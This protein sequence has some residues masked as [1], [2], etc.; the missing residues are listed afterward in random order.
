MK[1]KIKQ[2]QR[3]YG[4]FTVVSMRNPGKTQELS[5]RAQLAVFN[6]LFHA[7]RINLRHDEWS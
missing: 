6:A 2:K 5:T 3:D 7:V 1:K 4:I